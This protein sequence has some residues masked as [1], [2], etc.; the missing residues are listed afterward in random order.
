MCGGKIVK[1]SSRNGN[2]YYACEDNKP[3]CNFRVPEKPEYDICPKCGKKV[4]SYTDADGKEFWACEDYELRKCT[5][6]TWDVPTKDFCPA[7][8][9]TLFK[10]SGRGQNKTF[11]ENEKCTEFVPLD[12]RGYKVKS[13][14]NTAK[15]SK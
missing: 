12:A 3:G 5:F 4:H 15:K 8:G 2:V 14:N 10:R 7:C 11:C 1:R 6:L 9:K 13:K